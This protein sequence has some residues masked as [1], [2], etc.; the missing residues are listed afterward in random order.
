V[1]FLPGRR[2]PAEPSHLVGAV[3]LDPIVSLAVAFAEA[4]GTC[5]CVFGAGVS[6]DAGVP[7]AWEIRQDGLR[8]LYQQ[9]TGAEELPSDEQFAGW[10]KENGHE[11]LDYSEVLDAIAPDRAVRR[12]L[13]A[14]YFD[15]VEPGEAHERLADLAAA[16]TIRVFITTNFDRL[17]EQALAARGVQPVVVSDDATLGAAPSREHAPVFIV[18]AHGDYMQETIRNTTEELSELPADLTDELRLIVD[19]HGLLVLGWRGSDPALSEI[20]RG[21]SPSRYGVWWLS[22]SETLAEPGRTLAEAVSARVIVRPSGAGSFL[23]ELASRVGT[24]TLHESGD[25]PGSVHDQVLNLVKR[26]EDVELDGLLRREQDAL[27]SAFEQVRANYAN[28]QPEDKVIAA[29]WGTLGTATDRRLASLIP[30][31]IYRPELLKAEIERDAARASNTQL[32]DGFEAWLEPWRLPFWVIGMALGALSLSLRRYAALG[33]ITSVTWREQSGYAVDFA[34]PPGELGEW[35]AKKYGP[36]SPNG[37]I[38]PSWNWL[39]QDL[40]QK[41]WLAD[42]YPD[43]LRREGEPNRSMV[44]FAVVMNLA[45]GLKGEHGYVAWWSPYERATESFV[46]ELVRDTAARE[47]VAAALGADLDTFDAKAAGILAAARGIGHFPEIRRPAEILA[48]LA[49]S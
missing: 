49:P 6:I 45:N 17:L 27:A 22:R 35:V 5:A 46:T 34:G 11:D 1:L 26:G 15:G 43:W 40:G 10:L 32:R 29:A 18:K 12:A 44:A 13:L 42:R 30:L 47:G 48:Q 25:D 2:C 33:A 19:R 16:G 21:R 14:G 9:D 39:V 23:A 28:R 24:F 38:F 3:P 31:A 20:I 37:W 41:E 8:R 4:P 36:Q 7:T